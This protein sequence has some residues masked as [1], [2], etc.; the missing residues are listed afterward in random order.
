MLILRSLKTGS[1]ND[2]VSL[3]LLT[4]LTDQSYISKVTL[5]RVTSVKSSASN[6]DI[7]ALSASEKKFPK[8]Y[9]QKLQKQDC[10]LR[11]QLCNSILGC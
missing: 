7:S 8:L 9:L 3:K 5:T 2:F 6:A 10:K 11:V 1:L 4:I